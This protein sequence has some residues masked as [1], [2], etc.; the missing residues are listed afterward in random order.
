M[1]KGRCHQKVA[2][3]SRDRRHTG[4]KE[5][6]QNGRAIWKAGSKKMRAGLVTGVG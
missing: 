5:T 6:R 2:I 4:T 3:K 1:Q